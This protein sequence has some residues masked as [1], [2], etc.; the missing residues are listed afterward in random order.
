MARGSDRY[1]FP[2]SFLT[3]VGITSLSGMMKCDSAQAE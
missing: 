2:V 1:T 3:V